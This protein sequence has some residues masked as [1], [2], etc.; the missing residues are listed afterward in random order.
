LQLYCLQQWIGLLGTQW[1]QV[2]PFPG[3]NRCKP[4]ACM[5]PM[6]PAHACLT[7]GLPGHA[8]STHSNE[9]GQLNSLEDVQG[10]HASASLSFDLILVSLSVPPPA[11]LGELALSSVGKLGT[12]LISCIQEMQSGMA[13]A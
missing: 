3:I 13:E 8:G 12:E 1:Q 7:D 5:V 2:T 4:T 11:Y 10:L 9:A 6:L